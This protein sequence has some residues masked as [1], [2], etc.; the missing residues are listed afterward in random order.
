MLNKMLKHYYKKFSHNKY[1]VKFGDIV[2]AEN[3]WHFN[4]ESVA[5]G[6]A[7]GVACGWIPLPF[8][9]ILAVM[10]AVF[11]DCNIP[12]VAVSIWI[13]NPITMPFM[14]Y[15]AY[16]L[17]SGLLNVHMSHVHFHLNMQQIII[18]LHDI[19]QPFLLGCLVAGLASGVATYLIIH[20]LWPNIHHKFKNNKW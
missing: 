10:I 2:C 6:I 8:H 15:F 11:L 13:A 3:L 5:R 1:I 19:W 7:V 9:T 4:R 14:Y 20:L 18:V 17:G 12:L 16:Q